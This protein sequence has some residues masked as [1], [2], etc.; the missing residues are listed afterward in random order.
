MSSRR[1]TRRVRESAFGSLRACGPAAAARGLD[2]PGDAARVELRAARRG[3]EEEA[4]AALLEDAL[5]DAARAGD[6]REVDDVRH[7]RDL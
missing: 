3:E 6:E 7:A 2:H 4:E 1:T 5:E